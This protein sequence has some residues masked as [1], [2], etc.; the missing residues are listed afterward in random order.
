MGKKDPKV[1]AY[2]KNA[3]PFAQPILRHL[4]AVIH[5]VSPD[6][7]ET[8][9]W[10]NPAY[11][12]KGLLCGFSGFKEH[13]TFGFWK[14]SQV[15]PGAEEAR[16]GFGKLKSVDDLPPKA[17]L[18]GYI[19][20]A[21][22]LNDEGVKPEWMA[23]RKKHKPLPVPADLKVA[24]SK[25]AKAKAGFDAFSPS[26][27]REYIEWITEAKAEATREKR[28]LTAIEWMAEG[29]RRNWKYESK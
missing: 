20:K 28:L 16:W 9:K 8:T 2:I 13:A 4:R 22:K 7:V 25:D 17:K 15:V 24:L 26:A 3:K 19:K 10:S 1:D 6:I 12:Y 11:E 18:V 29:K 23:K 5:S 21:M 14:H 27:Q